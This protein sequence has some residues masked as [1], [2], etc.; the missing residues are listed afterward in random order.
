MPERGDSPQATFLDETG[1]PKVE[2]QIL[3]TVDK[4]KKSA[5]QASENPLPPFPTPYEFLSAYQQQLRHRASLR[6]LTPGRILVAGSAESATA[7]LDP[8]TDTIT[9]TPSLRALPGERFAAVIIL[10]HSQSQTINDT[11]GRKILSQNLAAFTSRLA[12][13][14]SALIIAERI[15]GQKINKETKVR[16]A[17]TFTKVLAEDTRVQ[18]VNP[19]DI[20]GYLFWE[21]RNPAQADYRDLWKMGKA[22]RERAGQA[23]DAFKR[24]METANLV[25]LDETKLRAR[26]H[27]T[28][29]P[30]WTLALT[31]Q[32][33]GAIITDR[34]AIY[35]INYDGDYD[36]I[37]DFP[38]EDDTILPE[39][40][41]RKTVCLTPTSRIDLT[42][43]PT[44]P[45]G[46]KYHDYRCGCRFEVV[47]ISSK[48]FDEQARKEVIETYKAGNAIWRCPEHSQVEYPIGRP[49]KWKPLPRPEHH[50]TQTNRPKGY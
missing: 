9:S 1:S 14:Q 38:V 25:I 24:K 36:K 47:N 10:S 29:R 43:G 37:G 3:G 20:P 32:G 28:S 23:L 17:K 40:G 7:I 11:A 15:E 22:I 2:P 26:L 45:Y 30:G 46:I 35:E 31:R 13:R 41:I 42:L 39:H 16:R 27:H 48:R 44:L 49:E 12:Y 4:Q 6:E 21:A 33:V 5:W 19:A 34:K 18:I 50:H 8:I